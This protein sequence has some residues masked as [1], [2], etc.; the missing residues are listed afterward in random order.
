MLKANQPLGRESG[1][2][3]LIAT[4]TYRYKGPENSPESI[5]QYGSFFWSRRPLER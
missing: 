2:G 4:V 3:G 5:S 1:F